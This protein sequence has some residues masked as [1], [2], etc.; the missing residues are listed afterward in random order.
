MVLRGCCWF[1]LVIADL[2]S[3]LLVSFFGVFGVVPTT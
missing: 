1:D 2:S 3:F